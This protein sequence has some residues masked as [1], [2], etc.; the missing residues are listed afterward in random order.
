METGY[1]SIRGAQGDER[2]SFSNSTVS[3]VGLPAFINEMAWG[4]GR[5]ASPTVHYRRAH[6]AGLQATWCKW[7][8][9]LFAPECFDSDFG[10]APTVVRTRSPQTWVRPQ[11]CLPGQACNSDRELLHRRSNRRPRCVSS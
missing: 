4:G 7:L 10:T 6:I 5:V 3:T 2:A 8:G 11:T 1:I 9:E